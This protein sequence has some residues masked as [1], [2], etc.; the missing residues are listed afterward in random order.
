VEIDIKALTAMAKKI[1]KNIRP[2]LD[3][4]Y[5]PDGR[6]IYLL[7]EGRLVNLAAAEGHPAAVMDMSF[8]TQALTVRWATA[9]K[10]PLDHRVHLVP[11]E[12]EEQV[13]TLKLSSMGIKFDRL[14][15]EQKRYLASWEFGT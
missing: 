5:L 13:A 1:E 10:K 8:A 6:W 11:K 7:G 9:N 14:T 4:Y 2:N 12:V 15:A 3:G